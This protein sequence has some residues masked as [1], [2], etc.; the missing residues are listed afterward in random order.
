MGHAADAAALLRAL[1][2]E[3]A[4]ASALLRDESI[5]L[6]ARVHAVRRATKRART[7]A[8]VLKPVLD[9]SGEALSGALRAAA[10]A[11]AGARD[12]KV[13]ADTA[14]DLSERAEDEAAR[15]VL[16]DVA[17]RVAGH[18]APAPDLARAMADLDAAAA[19]LRA[20]PAVGEGADRAVA[21]RIATLYRRARR[22]FGA[23]RAAPGTDALHDWRK[24]VKDRLHIA[25]LAK[26]TW[27]ERAAPRPARLAKLADVLGRDHDLAMLAAAIPRAGAGT[28]KARALVRARRERLTAKALDLGATLF[29]QKPRRVRAAWLALAGPDEAR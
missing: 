9:S 24:G 23:A 21:G 19:I 16:A 17:D 8:R 7:L 22:E 27:P 4:A 13:V 5:D 28:G 18:A 14:R 2:D 6:H 26:R 11:L 12:A 10:K 15:A 1:N 29:A 3:V 25:K 20:V